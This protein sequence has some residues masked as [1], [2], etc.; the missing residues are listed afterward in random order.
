ME[1]DKLVKLSGARID[2]VE[3]INGFNPKGWY[4]EVWVKEE[5]LVDKFLNKIKSLKEHTWY[6]SYV[7]DDFY[8]IKECKEI[9]G[10]TID[11]RCIIHL[12]T[13]FSIKGGYGQKS[14]AELSELSLTPVEIRQ[15]ESA[16]MAEYTK[17]GYKQGVSVKQEVGKIY[18]RITY[19][20]EIGDHKPQLFFTNDSYM[21][22]SVDGKCIK[23]FDE[24]IWAPIVENNSLK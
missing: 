19:T 11:P 8:Y 3:D 22:T 14:L 23:V 9:G 1:K 10:S 5:K 15:V 2:L 18:N 7:S 16:L 12:C 4:G 17:R 20:S 21:V 6:K 24:G 13:Y